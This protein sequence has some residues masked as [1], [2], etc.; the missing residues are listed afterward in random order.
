MVG[1]RQPDRFS[2]RKDIEGSE[3][4]SAFTTQRVPWPWMVKVLRERLSGGWGGGGE[5][6]VQGAFGR[7]LFDFS[8]R[9]HAKTEEERE[10]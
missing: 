9:R 4:R 1:L 3:K 2:Q 10:R 5:P 7:R 6:A 8:G